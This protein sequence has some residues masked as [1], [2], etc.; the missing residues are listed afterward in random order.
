MSVDDVR[1]VREALN[2]LNQMSAT[3]ESST[4]ANDTYPALARLEARIAELER[5]L[6]EIDIRSLDD[7]DAALV[8]RA[9]AADEEGQ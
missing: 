8:R 6:R 5:A 2:K 1:I 4:L 9:L 7:Y 3:L